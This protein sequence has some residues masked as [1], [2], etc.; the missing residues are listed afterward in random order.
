MMTFRT[1]IIALTAH[2]MFGDRERCLKAQMDEYLSK[3]LKPALLVQTI[4]KC[5][6]NMN[7]RKAL[8]RT[9]NTSR[10]A[11]SLKNGFSGGSNSSFKGITPR[12]EILPDGDNNNNNKNNNNNNNN[13]NNN[14]NNNN[15]N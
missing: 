8:S 14:N 15:N 9:Q 12:I 4:A 1:P 5:V 2:A 10:F 7:Q 13:K 11:E 3:P 6:H